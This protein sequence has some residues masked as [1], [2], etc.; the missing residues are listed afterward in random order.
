MKKSVDL[1]EQ[2]CRIL[3]LSD[4]PM[5]ESDVS[6]MERIQRSTTL[7]LE[8]PRRVRV[9]WTP[10]ISIAAS[11]TLITFI[12]LRMFQDSP[13]NDLT[14][15]GTANV[16][17][18]VK[19]DG[20]TR[21]Y[22]GDVKLFAGDQVAAEVFVT[23]PSLALAVV[24]NSSGDMLSESENLSRQFEE[25]VSGETTMLNRSFVLDSDNEGEVLVVYTCSLESF[26]EKFPDRDMFSRQIVALTDFFIPESLNGVCRAFVFPLR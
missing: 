19:R 11:I 23:E 20:M 13:T 2:H 18:Y 1:F 6:E 14:M 25:L 8:L 21:L 15:K 5:R 7:P 10:V 3:D 26:S 24:Y 17:V 16:V 22:D 4:E 12:G 9:R